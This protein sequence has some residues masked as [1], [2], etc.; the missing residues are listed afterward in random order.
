[1]NVFAVA[2]FV[3]DNQMDAQSWFSILTENRIPTLEEYEGMRLF[4][5]SGSDLEI[6]DE[7]FK[8]LN[9]GFDMDIRSMS[10]GD[11]VRI[12]RINGTKYYRCSHGGWK[13]VIF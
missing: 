9:K 7:I 11:V 8:N 10:V 13:Q 4:E 2:M 1:M 5:L 12:D 3:K 6:C